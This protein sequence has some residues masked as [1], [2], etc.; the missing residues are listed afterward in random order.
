M[1]HTIDYTIIAAL[2]PRLLGLLFFFAFGGLLLQIKGLIGENGLLPAKVYFDSIY[3]QIGKKGYYL[4]PSIFWWKSSNL[5]L[6]IGLGAGIILSVLLMFGVYPWV[7]LPLLYLLHLSIMSAG[8]D[9]LS[10]G[11]EGFLLEITVQGFLLSLT[12]VPNM[13][14]WISI[15]FLVFRFHL[16][17]G[18]IKLLTGDKS[19]RDLTALSFHYLTQP[20]PNIV[21]WYVHKLPLWLHKFSTA[22]CLFI[23]IVIPFGIFF[24]EDIRLGVFALLFGLQLMIW[25]TG[26]FSYLNY[27]TVVLCTVLL[28]NAVLSL[29]FQAP[30]ITPSPLWLEAILTVLGSCLLALQMMRL[31]SDFSH[32]K[33][34]EAIL[35]KLY[36]LHL[37]HRHAIFASMTKKRYEVIIEGS[38][39]GKTWKEYTCRFKP[40]QLRSR[41]FRCAPYQPRLD[42]QMW[43][44]PLSGID[45][46]WYDRLLYHVL[47]GTPEVLALLK[48]NP[49]PDHPP[50]YVRTLLYDYTY[51]SFEEKRKTGNWWK[52]E[53]IGELTHPVRLK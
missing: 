39:D 42:W 8:Q 22:A 34:F 29:F 35:N 7:I 3:K 15:N 33:Y 20:L 46:R 32:N 27:I 38:D 6:Y 10:F 24:S 36:P 21:A 52:R 48:E 49:F 37:V 14:V 40:S 26:N 16:Q 2:F 43:F 30:E 45:K 12:T 47:K 19:W 41:P 51:T 17:A 13:M 4:L 31:W 23:E 44:L 50:K 5:A 18:A 1:F 53:L 28:N 11:W 9:F 25:G